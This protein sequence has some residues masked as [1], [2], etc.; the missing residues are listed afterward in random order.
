MSLDVD[1]GDREGDAC[2]WMYGDGPDADAVVRVRV[3]EVGRR[4]Y[5]LICGHLP[6]AR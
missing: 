4:Q 6:A 5:T 3:R 1:V 2:T